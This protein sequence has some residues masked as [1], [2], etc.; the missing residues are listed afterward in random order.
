MGVLDELLASLLAQGGQDDPAQ[1]GQGRATQ[2]QVSQGQLSGLAQAV[3]AMLN[4]PRVGGIQGLARRLQEAGLGDVVSSWIGT[5]QNEPIDPRQLQ[6][7][8]PDEITTMSRQAGLPP[9]QGG[10]LLAQLLPA[11][12]D[13]LTPKGR[14]PPQNE[15]GPLG[16]QLLQSLFR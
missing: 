9:Q 11:L 1:P 13:Q 6:E 3:I 5:G 8:M 16:T 14:V 4:D 10:S 7:A 12:I 2:G 15:M